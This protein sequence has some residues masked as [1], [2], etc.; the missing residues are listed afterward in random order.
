MPITFDTTGLGGYE[1]VETIMT[2][3]DHVLIVRLKKNDQW[4][5]CKQIHY[6]DDLETYTGAYIRETNILRRLKH[7][8]IVNYVDAVHDSD[9]HICNVMT[10]WCPGGDLFDR[11]NNA[12][13]NDLCINPQFIMRMAAHVLQGLQYVH[14]HRII[15][16]D[17]KPEN[18]CFDAHDRAKLIDFG[19]SQIMP[20]HKT[21]M[22]GDM[23]IGGTD[24]YVSPELVRRDTYDFTIDIW[25]L[26]VT[27][28]FACTAGLP[29]MGDT[30]EELDKSIVSA[31]YDRIE[32]DNYT[33][34][35]SLI[36]KMLVADKSKRPPASSFMCNT[37][38]FR[39][40]LENAS[41][42]DPFPT[43]LS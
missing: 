13:T 28:Y 4:C 38:Q 32:D 25:A 2:H 3:K 40:A 9:N 5:V 6:K 14:A 33:A 36:Q 7:T 39:A 30:P 23:L 42:S 19:L 16:C 41:R 18:I 11:I 35:D 21:C 31:R 27:L 10:E 17:I 37:S 1:Y 22:N 15:H 8:N 12:Y 20:D 26:G 24:Q 34:C 43:F 29:F